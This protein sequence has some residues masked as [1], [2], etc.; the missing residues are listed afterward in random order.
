MVL[1]DTSVWIRSFR[2]AERYTSRLYELLALDEVV[3]H[4]LV[5]GELLIGDR[6]GRKG[7]LE[8]YEAYPQATPVAHSQLV[9]FVR[10][11]RLHASGIGWID[12]NLLASAL[13]DGVR[14]WT[15][16]ARFAEVAVELGVAYKP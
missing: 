4:Q 3:G 10:T 8:L 6:G 9:E 16:D 14:L 11:R 5:Y 7:F 2:R 12:A 15:A 13:V 1:I